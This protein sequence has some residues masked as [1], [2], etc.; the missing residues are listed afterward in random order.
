MKIRS[1]TGE[2]FPTCKDFEIVLPERG[3]VLVT[4]DNGAGKSSLFL[5]A[6]ATALWNETLRGDPLWREG[7]ATEVSV[8]F[9][10]GGGA[11]H[12]RARRRRTAAKAT[13]LA[14][15]AVVPGF[16]W[17]PIKYENTTKGQEMLALLVGDFTGWRRTSVFSSADSDN[18]TRAS[19]GE[20][21]RLLETLIGND[22]FDPAMEACRADVRS[23]EARI[24]IARGRTALL[25]TQLQG[26]R[27][28]IDDAQKSLEQLRPVMPVDQLQT[29]LRAAASL[30][31]DVDHDLDEL[32]KQ[33]EEW[34]DRA[35]SARGALE[36]DRRRIT[37]LVS[38]SECPT[39]EQPVTLDWKTTL[40]ERLKHKVDET[41]GIDPQE[42]AGLRAQQRELKAE[43][44]QLDGRRAVFA[45]QL[46]SA[47]DNDSRRATAQQRL[48][49][50]Q[51]D[52][53]KVEQEA[54]ALGKDLAAA[55]LEQLELQSCDAV[56]GL[57]GVRAHLLGKALGGLELVANIWLAKIG[58]GL[59]LKLEP[60]TEKKTGGVSDSISLR[61]RRNN[62]PW[63]GYKSFSGGE[64]RRID[65]A[66]LMA[67]KEL[68]GAALEH[69]AGTL[70]FDEVFDALDTIGVDGIVEV[71]R[72]LTKDRTAI[73]IT[74]ST[75]LAAKL[76]PAVR[77]HVQDGKAPQPK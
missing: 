69:H 10:A 44:E 58:G 26:M 48:V 57:K 41:V 61:A 68:R 51:A 32:R 18:W 28:R 38:K 20:R 4:G 33:I 42:E 74:H 60:Y 16:D 6:P 29:Q 27:A 23:T 19:D 65:V 66:A 59:Q 12:V 11:S 7:I 72:E 43:R 67:L 37:G 9:D 21:K 64:R 31:K 52:V 2:G 5:D 24:N 25:D 76:S 75:V 39:C 17:K 46:S 70:W 49:V 35:S 3:V 14:H 54:A 50:V 63:R 55:E 73:V 36:A 77:Y 62:G 40:L 53:A 30:V 22:R 1:I 34:S 71:L 56:L 47:R 15:G 13:S 45:A 8:D